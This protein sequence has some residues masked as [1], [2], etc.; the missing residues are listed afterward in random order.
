MTTKFPK[1]LADGWYQT[2]KECLE[3]L[4]EPA[5]QVKPDSFT[6]FYRPI[7]IRDYTIVGETITGELYTF[8]RKENAWVAG[9]VRQ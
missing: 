9:V 6:R 4:K 2:T 8:S 7:L 1:E 5:V 3:R